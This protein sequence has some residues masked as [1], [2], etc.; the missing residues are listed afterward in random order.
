MPRLL[1]QRLDGHRIIGHG[2][3]TVSFHSDL[4]LILDAKAGFFVSYNSP[5]ARRLILAGSSLTSS[6]NGISQHRHRTNRRSRPPRRMPPRGWVYEVSRRFETN[7]LAVTTVLGETK[8]T[9]NPKDNTISMGVKGLNQQPEHFREIA[10]M[11][12]RAVDGNA[13]IAFAP[14]PCG[15]RIAYIDYPFMVFQQVSDTFDKQGVNYFILG[16]CLCVIALTL[17]LWPVAAMIRKHYGKPLT[18]DP[19][20]KRLRMLV[21]LVCI[22]VVAFVVGC[23]CLSAKPAT[24]RFV[25]AR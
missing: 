8:I 24:L 10:P 9:V 7:V 22:G 23:W 2:G 6:W 25:G 5:G 20:A 11:V 17:L 16:F 4:H 18:L 19:R 14:D 3:D 13:K 1:R 12:F 21:R 15:R